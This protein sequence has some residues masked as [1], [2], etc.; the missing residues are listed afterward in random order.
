MRTKLSVILVLSLSLFLVS[1]ASAA[2]RA[3]KV[4]ADGVLYLE[5]G[6]EM[7]E[8]VVKIDEEGGIKG[9]GDF[10]RSVG[11]PWYSH[12][13]PTCLSVSR[14][15]AWIGLAT[16]EISIPVPPQYLETTM[17]LQVTDQGARL[18]YAVPTSELAGKGLGTD[19]NDQGDFFG[20]VG[21]NLWQGK[22]KIR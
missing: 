10:Q 12:W 22:F 20:A 19:C 11:E 15:T 21:S 1:I 7:V 5:D 6:F 8:F 9:H 3:H 4:S 16:T 18:S 17:Q 13:E 2:R 14:D